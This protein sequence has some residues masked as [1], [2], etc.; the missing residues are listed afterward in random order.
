MGYMHSEHR[1][2]DTLIAKTDDLHNVQ[3]ER[4]NSLNERFS[5]LG[6]HCFAQQAAMKG[7]FYDLCNEMH[8]E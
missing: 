7:S 3:R 6:E 8:R 2:V 5:S 4:E 1:A